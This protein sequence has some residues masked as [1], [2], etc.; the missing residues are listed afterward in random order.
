[1]IGQTVRTRI[2]LRVGEFLV[3]K[4][5]R[6][7]IRFPLDLRLEK[8][9]SAQ[10]ARVLFTSVVPL[11]QYLF[12]LGGGEQRQVEERAVWIDYNFPQEVLK[13]LQEARNSLSFETIGVVFEG[14]SEALW[15]IDDKE[16]EIEFGR[17]IVDRKGI[18]L[19]TEQI[20][21]SPTCF[22]HDEHRLE[23]RIATGH[24]LGPEFSHQ[25]LE[26]EIL[27]SMS[28]RTTSRVL[29]SNCR[30]VGLP[31]SRLRNTIMLAK[32]PTTPASSARVRWVIGDPTEISSCP[33]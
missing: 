13:M 24:S 22:F 5:D 6:D 4:S 11:L 28:P 25:L 27:V 17:A 3:Q 7:R 12:S 10:I 16:T 15:M 19:Q 29:C 9:M 18:T 20:H 21:L 33:V 14:K 26:R 31:S 1:M 23:E 8:V 32:K 30:K 2:Q